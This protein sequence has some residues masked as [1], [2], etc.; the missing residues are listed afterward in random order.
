MWHVVPDHSVLHPLLIIL[1][2][3]LEDH[4]AHGLN[5]RP[6]IGGQFGQIILND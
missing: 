4:F 2:E 6:P 1:V 3:V 5:R